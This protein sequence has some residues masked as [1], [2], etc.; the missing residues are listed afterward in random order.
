MRF[1]SITARDCGPFHEQTLPE[2]APGMN[3]I[4]GPNEAGK[5]SW[6]AALYAGLCGMRRARGTR[7]EDKEFG[8]RHRPWDSPNWEVGAVIALSDGR[9]IELR[10]DLAGRVDSSARDA[11]LAGRDYSS[12]VMNDGAPDGS[13]WLGL[14]RRSFLSTACVRQTDIL[15]VLADP[16]S[17]QEDMQRAS[18]TAGTDATAGGPN[19]P[20]ARQRPSARLCESARLL[21]GC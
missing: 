3:V 17:L 6:H 20:C 1:E 19:P 15:S 13:R 7:S 5:S 4:Y 14:N 16:A 9:R 12:E 8:E 2:F 10:H 21:P 18:T 11:D